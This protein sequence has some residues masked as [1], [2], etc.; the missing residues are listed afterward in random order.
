MK[1]NSLSEVS[2]ETLTK[3]KNLLKG[4][5]I[6]FALVMLFAFGALLYLA[7]KK[8]NYSLLAV[9]PAS[10]ITLLPIWIRFSQINQEI[11]SRN[12]G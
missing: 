2:I 8:G 3:Q 11:K 10:M 5:A 9:W 1:K 6:G 4:V 12:A 7:T